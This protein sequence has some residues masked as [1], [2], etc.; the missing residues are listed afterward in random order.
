M[1]SSH[2]NSRTSPAHDFGVVLLL[3]LPSIVGTAFFLTGA[4]VLQV[5]GPGDA[6]PMNWGEATAADNV[7]MAIG[8]FVFFTC[9]FG[10][11]FGP[12]LLPFAVWPCVK[13]AR[14]AGLRSKVA[15]WSWTF[16]LLGVLAAAIFYGWL[17]HLDLFI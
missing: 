1:P 2:D 9:Y 11:G 6:P 5:F 14:A 17:I 3:C 4:I 15:I 12:G 8:G 10:A 7:K 13:I 16:V